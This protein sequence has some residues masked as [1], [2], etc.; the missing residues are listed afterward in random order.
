MVHY[1]VVFMKFDPFSIFQEFLA[2]QRENILLWV[3]VF[4]GLGSAA[5]FSLEQ[6]PSFINGGAGVAAS[7]TLFLALFRVYR[8]RHDS[9]LV[10]CGLIIAGCGFFT[11]T[12]FM[13]AQVKTYLVQTPMLEKETRPVMVEGIL[14][15]R[16]EQ[17]GKKGTLLFL[18]DVSIQKWQKN[19]TPTNIRITIRKKTDITAGDRVRLLV[20]LAPVSPPVAPDSYDFARHYYYEGIGALGYALSDIE[21]IQKAERKFWNLEQIRT[22]IS[23]IIKSSVPERQAGIV[24]ALMTGERAAISDEDWDALRASG[25]AHIISISGLHVVMVAAPVFFTIRLF[26]SFF[27]FLA[28]RYPIKKIAA[29]IALFVCCL[30]VGLVVPSVPTTRALLMTGVG[31][32][33][34]MLDRS[35]F[36]LRL[37]AFSAILI[38]IIS[39]E[40]IWSVSF[41]MSFAAVTALVAVA[42]WGRPFVSRQYRDAGWIKRIA[43]F[44]I[45][46]LM[47]S[48]VAG[49]AT[50]PFSL[51]HFQQVASYSVLANALSVPISGIIIMPMLIVS[52]ILMPFGWAGESLKMMALGVDWLL[53]VARWTQNLYG[54]VITSPAMPDITM[55]MITLSGLVM[56]LFHG[57]HR[58]VAVLPFGIAILSAIFFTPPD[59]MVSAEGT[60]MAVREADKIYVSSARRDKFSVETWLKRWNKTQEDIIPF[61]RQGSIDLSAV[62]GNK[63]SCD[64][65]ACRIIKDNIKIAFGSGI[66]E[67]YQDCGWADVIISDKRLPRNFC[68]TGNVRQFGYYE[69]KKSGS[70]SITGEVRDIKTG[71]QYRGNRPWVSGYSGYHPAAD[72]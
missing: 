6:E 65:A 22:R 59:I 34:I 16:E 2:A 17:E 60:V 41:Q 66:Y 52:Y 64:P 42:E 45:G 53:D 46:T 62:K 12:G 20:K 9:W 51:Y 38:L 56:I 14:E 25:L 3:P 26:L 1:Q 43:L 13:A 36:S 27:P 28:L 39:P 69:F 35:P 37:V 21:V 11:M 18:S 54:S 23:D 50:A 61:P 30:Y 29:A 44:V 48:L 19:K 4:L 40:S 67:L 68:K 57:W 72:D 71:G 70:L 5:Y 10:L 7:L 15:H 58:A 63:I 47:T 32:T 8:K 49:L 55:V 24:S 31:L 33:A